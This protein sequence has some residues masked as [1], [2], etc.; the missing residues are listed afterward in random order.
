MVQLKMRRPRGEV[1]N[2]G[3]PEGFFIRTY[4]S[5]NDILPWA[6]ICRKGELL[7]PQGN[8]IEDFKNI[9]INHRGLICERDLFFVVRK[10][11][12]YPVATIAGISNKE[13]DGEN[14]GY[15]HMVAAHPDVR[16]LGIGN[17]MLAYALKKLYNDNVDYTILTTD[18]FRLPAIKTYINAG[19]IP[20]Q[21]DSDDP[22]G[23]IFR[24]KKV[25]ELL[26]IENIDICSQ[27]GEIIGKILL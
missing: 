9:I 19:F 26:K 11:D 10:S 18:D 5:E 8:Y 13:E 6:E 17:F 25:L 24:W 21:N 2:Y 14:W 16:G 27:N 1:K 22:D 4:Q 15:I 12:N 23:M 3:A 7:A 20:V